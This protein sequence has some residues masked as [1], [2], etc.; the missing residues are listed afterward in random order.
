[1]VYYYNHPVKVLTKIFL[2]LFDLLLTFPPPGIVAE[3]DTLWMARTIIH[4]VG[5][6]ISSRFLWYWLECE[7][8]D[9]AVTLLLQIR[10]RYQ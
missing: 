9:D 1:M 8:R 5:V 2:A 3:D 10:S 6:A 4:V 7:W